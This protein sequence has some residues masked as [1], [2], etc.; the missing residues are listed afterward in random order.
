MWTQAM[1]ATIGGECE[2]NIFN[3]ISLKPLLLA[4]FWAI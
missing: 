1:Y 3:L 4:G 2:N